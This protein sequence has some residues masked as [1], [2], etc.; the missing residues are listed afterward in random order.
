MRVAVIGSG[1]REHAL[2]WKLAQSP[3]VDKIYAIPGNAGMEEIAECI[4]IEANNLERITRFSKDVDVV[5]V[6]PEK[7]LS[8]G[9]I[10]LIGERKGFGPKRA[11][12]RIESSK[13]FAKELM[14]R[15]GIPTACYDVCRLPEEAFLKIRAREYPFVIKASGLA[16]GKGAFV[17]KTEKEAKDIINKLMV[18]RILGN[19]GKEVV[20]EDFLEGEELSLLAFTDGKYILPLLPS[21]DHKRLLE[22]DDG[23]NTGGMGAY[24]PVPF[25]SKEDV[26]RIV[27]RILEPA[28]IGLRK[29]DLV[30]KGILYAGLM[31]TAEGPKVLEFNARFGDPETQAILPLVDSDLMELILATLD[32]NLKVIGVDFI[33]GFATCVVLA[34]SGYPEKYEKGKEISGLDSVRG[35][36]VFHAGTNRIKDR[37][38]TNGG[39]VLGVTGLGATLKESIDRTYEEARKIHFEGV[40]MRKDI[41]NRV[42]SGDLRISKADRDSA[43]L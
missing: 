32:E 34:S 1:G 30:Y 27:D 11:A 31:I 22:G 43:V 36:L 12:A 10:D 3:L 41:G 16:S 39:R 40:Y 35:A 9:L 38:L 4:N 13:V 7:P 2:V 5:V 15:M 14:N 42:A 23:P 17:V 24:S 26:G 29:K 28:V 19:S 21:Q 33:K 8:M 37:V 20:I 6:G 25:I 18:E